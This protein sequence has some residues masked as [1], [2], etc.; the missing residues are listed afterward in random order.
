MGF[1]SLRWVAACHR[2]NILSEQKANVLTFLENGWTLDVHIF[3]LSHK[4]SKGPES[5][6]KKSVW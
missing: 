6:P 3:F 4:L 1:Q 5:G 2:V